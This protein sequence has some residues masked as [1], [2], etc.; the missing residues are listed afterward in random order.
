MAEILLHCRAGHTLGTT[1]LPCVK[2]S[3]IGSLHPIPQFAPNFPTV[4][5]WSGETAKKRTTDGEKL[6]KK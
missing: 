4:T 1:I 2:L 5:L 3:N 6:Q